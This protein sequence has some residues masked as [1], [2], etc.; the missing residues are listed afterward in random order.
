MSISKC[1]QVTSFKRADKSIPHHN[2]EHHQ[3]H[4]ARR[5]ACRAEQYRR[6]ERHATSCSSAASICTLAMAKQQRRAPET[7]RKKRA[8]RLLRRT[9]LNQQQASAHCMA[10]RQVLCTK[11]AARAC[12]ESQEALL[13]QC[14]EVGQDLK[15]VAH[16]WGG[17]AVAVVEF[18]DLGQALRAMLGDVRR[19]DQFS[20]LT[21]RSEV[22][23]NWKADD[24]EEGWRSGRG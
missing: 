12:D 23:E 21:N 13:V 17:D 24:D 3:G 7:K 15:Q 19:Q 8:Q 20:S 2:R 6:S 4:N 16:G 18:D 11:A 5:P 10:S 14:V 22:M 1:L 9:L